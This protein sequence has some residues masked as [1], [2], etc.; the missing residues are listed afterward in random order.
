MS[1]NTTLSGI[2]NKIMRLSVLLGVGLL[3]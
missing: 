3:L 1:V 2:R